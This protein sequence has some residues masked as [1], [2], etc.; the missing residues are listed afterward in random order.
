MDAG[1]FFEML[2]TIAG[3]IAGIAI[4]ALVISPKAITAQVIQSVA[5]GY[6]NDI[7]VAISPVTGV[8]VQPN[9]SYPNS[10]G[11][12]LPNFSIGS[13]GFQ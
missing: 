1:K 11:F 12:G 9:L 13:P 4:V 10:G 3:L 8:Q 7:A 5:S 2:M 6:G